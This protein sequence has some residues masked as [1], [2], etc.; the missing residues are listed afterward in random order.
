MQFLHFTHARNTGVSAAFILFVCLIAVHLELWNRIFE[1][2]LPRWVICVSQLCP[3]LQSKR[4]FWC[5]WDASVPVRSIAMS[6]LKTYFFGNHNCNSELTLLIQD[7][8]NLHQWGTCLSKVQ[9]QM[10]KD[11]S[12]FSRLLDFSAFLTFRLHSFSF[13]PH[14]SVKMVSTPHPKYAVHPVSKRGAG[15]KLKFD[16]Q[17]QN[18]QPICEHGEHSK[19]LWFP[20]HVHHPVH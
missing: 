7:S 11:F 8:G 20:I 6:V 16:W 3:T 13:N 18:V 15:V 1:S 9:L 17:D 2:L 4:W 12:A 10:K 19:S 14:P 5:F